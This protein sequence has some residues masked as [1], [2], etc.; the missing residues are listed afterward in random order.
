M[1]LY[2]PI[3]SGVSKCLRERL[4]DKEGNRVLRH[5]WK[6]LTEHCGDG[7]Y[8][9]RGVADRFSLLLYFEKRPD[10]EKRVI[11]ITEE[12]QRFAIPSASINSPGDT[13]C[14]SGRFQRTNA[15]APAS[16]LVSASYLG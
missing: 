4:T 11:K 3:N 14:P 8:A 13:I 12:I 2:S 5:V 6:V 16:L 7:E 9:G 1:D 10:I 15:S